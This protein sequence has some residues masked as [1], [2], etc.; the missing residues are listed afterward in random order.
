[1]DNIQKAFEK[2]GIWPINGMD[3]IAKLPRSKAQPETP[4]G[5]IK[6]P[7]SAK[8]IR[9]FKISYNRS[10][11]QLKL[12][13]LFEALSISTAN[14][15]LLKHKVGGLKEAIILQKKNKRGKEVKPRRG[16]VTRLCGDIFA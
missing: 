2:A 4:R 12:E 5:D 8:A 9:H 14:V 6:P 11:L 15:S 7:T 13:K 16:R 10:P 3:I 1:V